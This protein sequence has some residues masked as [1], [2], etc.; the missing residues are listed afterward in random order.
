M[1]QGG[2]GGAAGRRPRDTFFIVRVDRGEHEPAARRHAVRCSLRQRFRDGRLF[3]GEGGVVLGLRLER[4][5]QVVAV[6]LPRGL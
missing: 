2:A 1:P 4:L 6:R 3:L 5:H